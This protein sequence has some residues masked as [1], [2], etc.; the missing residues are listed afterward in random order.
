MFQLAYDYDSCVRNSEKVAW[1]VD[2]VLPLG[3]SL[4][5]SRPFLPE[6]LSGEHNVASLS[7]AERTTLNQITGNAYLNLF[8][9]VEEYIVATAVQHAQA[10]LFG[11]HSALRALVRFAE[12]EVKHQQLFWRYRDAFKRD[13]STPCDVLGSAAE[14][15]GVILSK[16][17]IA[18]LMV[19]LHLEIMTQGHYVDSV[20]D[21]TG[22]DPLFAK[23][24]KHHW[25]E[26]SQHARIDALELKK[27]SDGA[28][29]QQ[30]VT[31]FDDYLGL[32]DAFDG[33]LASQAKMDAV[34]LA[35]ALSRSLSDAESAEIVKAQHAAYRHTFLILGM[36][37]PMFLDF[38][39]KL[40]AA[41]ADRITAKADTLRA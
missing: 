18:V 4:D 23:L 29:A 19:T 20:R 10:E 21:A 34:S 27:F 38:M 28:S 35:R 39:K 17:P 9:F 11:D 14:V 6:S 25:L 26:E 24:L 7:P 2:D 15:A 12:E 22:I 36:E 41:D 31:A 8:A 1:S 33:L 13:F 16:S 3:T 32:I 37:N 5:F 30:I 40:S